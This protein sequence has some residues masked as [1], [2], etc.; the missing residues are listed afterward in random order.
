MSCLQFLQYVLLCLLFPALRSEIPRLEE[1]ADKHYT[2]TLAR[3][4]PYIIG[5]LLGCFLH[6]TNDKKIH[7]NKVQSNADLYRPIERNEV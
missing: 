4:P 2:Q 1:F 7:I 6:Q 3:M 5:I